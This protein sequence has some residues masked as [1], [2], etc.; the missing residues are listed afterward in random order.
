MPDQF[1]DLSNFV[2]ISIETALTGLGVP[3]VNT[4][5]LFT[6]DTPSWMTPFKVYTNATDVATDFGSSSNA[7]KIAI[8]FFSQQPNVLTTNGYLVI[9]TLTGSGTEKI[10]DAIARTIGSIYYFGVLLDQELS[11]DD[12]ANAAAYV[13]TVDKMMFYGSSVAAKYA[14]GGALDLIRTAGDTHTRALYYHTGTEIDTQRMAAAYAG[15]A[16]STNFTGSGTVQT[17]HGKTLSVIT[18]D[19]TVDQT[20]LTACQTAGVDIYANFFGSPKVFTSGANMFFDQVYN[21][22]WFK[23]ALQVAIF[24]FLTTTPTKIPQTE[25]GMDG[26]KNECRKICAQAVRN[27]YAAPGTW[28]SPDVFGDPEALIRCVLDIGYYVYSTPLS[29]QST[30][31][32]AARKAALIQI[33]LK[34]AGAEH[35]AN[36]IGLIND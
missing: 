7:A 1:L 11:D 13:Q 12:L 35:S 10:E 17:M 9:I 15:R 27:G 26:L 33:A 25:A 18:P 5:A 28:T 8:A 34:E 4:A 36:V 29:L 16:L 19:A 20:A 14:P 24:N 30:A 22:L 6:R 2:T 21:A 3:N 31:D 32:R 23:A